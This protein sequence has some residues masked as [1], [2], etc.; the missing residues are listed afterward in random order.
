MIAIAPLLDAV[1][2]ASDA[3]AAEIGR[4]LMRCGVLVTLWMLAGR[5]VK[6]F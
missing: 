4:A 5:E 1:A 2:G 6:A 3:K